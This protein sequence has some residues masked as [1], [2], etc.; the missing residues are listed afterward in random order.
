[1]TGSL[2][3][4]CVSIHAP[5]PEN[6]PLTDVIVQ[7]NIIYDSGRDKPLLDGAPKR[8]R[9]HY[10]YAVRIESNGTNPPQGLHFMGNI[11]HPG[12]AGI[13]CGSATLRAKAGGC[14]GRANLR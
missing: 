4:P 13:Q 1:M 8:S 3:V 11:F 5:L 6:P 10:K 2:L 14:R 9:P 12:T 7:G